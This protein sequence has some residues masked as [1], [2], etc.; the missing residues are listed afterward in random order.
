MLIVFCTN[1]VKLIKR[2]R[3][4]VYV[5]SDSFT[6]IIRSMHAWDLII[7]SYINYYH[8]R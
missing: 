7:V 2:E 1:L 8:G 5:V 3:S 6:S 4:K